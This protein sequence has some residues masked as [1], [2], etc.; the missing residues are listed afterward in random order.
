MPVTRF[1]MMQRNIDRI[2]AEESIKSLTVSASSQSGEGY[3][4]GMEDLRKQ[5]GD[6]VVYRH[7]QVS[8]GPQENEEG[9][10]RAGI[11]MLKAMSMQRIGESVI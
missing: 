7:A 6:I 8:A 4:K 10:D 5:L 3:K 1:W 9:P 2:A 11:A